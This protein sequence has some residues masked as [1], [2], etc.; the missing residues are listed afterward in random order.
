[1]SKT[2]DEQDRTRLEELAK[3]AWENRPRDNWDELEEKPLE[4]PQAS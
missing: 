3:D 1:M 4:V 2:D